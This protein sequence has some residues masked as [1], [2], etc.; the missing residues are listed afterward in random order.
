MI[1]ELG[2]VRRE[3]R[4]EEVGGGMVG[5]LVG[6]IAVAIVYFNFVVWR[7][8]REICPSYPTDLMINDQSSVV[9]WCC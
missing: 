6:F 7:C 2:S 4:E 8:K 5:V 3:R 9:V 1:W